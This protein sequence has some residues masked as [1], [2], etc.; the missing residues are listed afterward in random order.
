MENAIM[1][2]AVLKPVADSSKSVFCEL[3]D[4]EVY[5]AGLGKVKKKLS[6]KV[7]L[8]R[9]NMYLCIAKDTYYCTN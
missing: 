4:S 1:K 3:F 8:L 2:S 5:Y 6:I 9:N 7:Y